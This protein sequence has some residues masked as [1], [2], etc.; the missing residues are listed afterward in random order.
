MSQI[1]PL[2]ALTRRGALVLALACALGHA[3][4]AKGAGGG[5][6]DKPPVA[7]SV[8]AVTSGTATLITIAGTA[9]MP[10]AVR[11]PEPLLIVVELP[12]VDGS[13]LAQSYNVASPLVG[14]VTVRRALREGTPVA[15]LSV[16]LRAPVRELPQK[17]REVVRRQEGQQR[18]EHRGEDPRRAL[19]VGK[20]REL[21]V[22]GVARIDEHTHA[23]TPDEIGT[24]V[25]VHGC[26]LHTIG[27]AL[28]RHRDRRPPVARAVAVLEVHDAADAILQ[29]L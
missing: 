1:K 22:G 27:R 2:L 20:T 21:G 6:A 13:Q 3:A 29:D 11:K 5:A 12:G 4:H 8:R 17:H 23:L 15:S 25:V 26:L 7:T 9:P 10:Y 14:S 24:R 28:E 18:R 16:T 19:D